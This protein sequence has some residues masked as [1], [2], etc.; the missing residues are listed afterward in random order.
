MTFLNKK[1]EVIKIELTPYGRHLLSLGK[2][3]PVYYSFFDDAIQYRVD[4]EAN[5]DIKK[6]ILE[7]TP[8][9]KPFY[10]FASVDR[11]LNTEERINDIERA[12]YPVADV[13]ANYFIYPMGT[14]ANTSGQFAPAFKAIYLHGTA[15]TS[16]KH[17]QPKSSSAGWDELAHLT[18]SYTHKNIPQVNSEIN[19]KISIQNTNKQRTNR[20]IKYPSPNQ[21]VSRIY[22]DGTFLE[23]E[24]EQN[25][26]YLTEENGFQHNESYEI[27]VFLYD[28][29]DERNLIPLKFAKEQQIVVNDMLIEAVP[30]TLPDGT[31][32]VTHETVEYYIDFRTD[33]T[34]P[35]EDICSGIE[36]LKSKEIFLDLDYDC[37]DRLGAVN[38]DIYR[39]RVRPEDIEDCG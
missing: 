12:T 24:E 18:S 39:S 29:T 28:E 31:Q 8:Y 37:P 33:K 5:T 32:L 10:S 27:E 19:Y 35:T 22:P 15:S 1:E 6:R 13:K 34:I 17:F 7:E 4:G 25:L 36:V 30:S 16:K 9:V 11:K 38:N 20:G 3:E 23:L 14:S 26:V 2:M 21:P